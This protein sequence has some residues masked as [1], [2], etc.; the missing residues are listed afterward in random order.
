M[1]KVTDRSAPAPYPV[2]WG[3]HA[4]GGGPAPR[5]P[6]SG[7]PCLA[8]LHFKSSIKIPRLPSGS[9]GK[10]PPANTGDTDLIPGLGRSH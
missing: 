8:Q 10:N 4:S 9:V 3:L 7:P 2:S 1:G 6:V 5:R